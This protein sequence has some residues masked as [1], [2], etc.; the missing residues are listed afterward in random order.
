VI[1]EDVDFEREQAERAM[2][3]CPR[4]KMTPRIE[5][6]PGVTFTACHC[7]DDPRIKDARA[8]VEPD[9][10]PQKVKMRWNAR[11]MRLAQR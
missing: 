7:A 3:A 11:V 6:E 2:G 8:I 1:L 10:N 5:Y 9:W 4:C